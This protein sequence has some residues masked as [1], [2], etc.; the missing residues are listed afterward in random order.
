MKHRAAAYG[1]LV[2]RNVNTAL[3]DA[4]VTPTHKEPPTLTGMIRI[5]ALVGRDPFALFPSPAEVDSARS[6]ALSQGRYP[7]AP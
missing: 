1:A 2:E 5:A 7:T 3:M 4:G 6:A